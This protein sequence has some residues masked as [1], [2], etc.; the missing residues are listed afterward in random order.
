LVGV[1][2]EGAK[3]K[4]LLVKAAAFRSVTPNGRRKNFCLVYYRA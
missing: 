2:K 3:Q 4:E 1:E